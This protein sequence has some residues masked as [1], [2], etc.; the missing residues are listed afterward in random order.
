MN[1][2]HPT[3]QRVVRHT[4]IHTYIHTYIDR[5]HSRSFVFIIR[6]LKTC[7]FVNILRLH[8]FTIIFSHVYY[9]YEK[10]KGF[11]FR[12]KRAIDR[13][14]IIYITTNALEETNVSNA[15]VCWMYVSGCMLWHKALYS[16][17]FEWGTSVVMYLNTGSF[18]SYTALS[19]VQTRLPLAPSSTHTNIYPL[20]IEFQYPT[21]Y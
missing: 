5:W 12:I 18:C 17:R 3:V 21:M 6:L 19:S 1:K 14:K 2:I 9:V 10:I 7:K 13:N 16:F 11:H 20:I 4:C 15:S 8:F